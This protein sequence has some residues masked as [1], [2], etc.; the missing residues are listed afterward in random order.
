MSI[1]LSIYVSV[2]NSSIYIYVHIDV[3]IF[4]LN[5]YV[6]VL[7]RYNEVKKVL[8]WKSDLSI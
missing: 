1:F 8:K 3:C 4:N 2:V 7:K 5:A 6:S